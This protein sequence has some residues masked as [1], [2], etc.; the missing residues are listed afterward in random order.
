MTLE[1]EVLV[2][3]ARAEKELT[4]RQIKDR[5]AEREVASDGTE[6]E[7][8]IDHLFWLQQIARGRHP[9]TSAVFTIT[10]AGRDAVEKVI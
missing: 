2:V 4:R 5:L 3:L 9:R 10:R 1:Q 8:A 6:V 7:S